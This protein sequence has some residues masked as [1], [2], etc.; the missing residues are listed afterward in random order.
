MPMLDNLGET[1][2][3]RKTQIAKTD[4]EE[5]KKNLKRPIANKKIK[6]AI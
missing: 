2:I 3:S 6:L 4:S 1:K 5:L